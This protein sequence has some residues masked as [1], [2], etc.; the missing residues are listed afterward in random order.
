MKKKY[1]KNGDPFSVA[2]YIM[3]SVKEKTFDRETV[4]T[5][6]IVAIGKFIELNLYKKS[7]E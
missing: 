7:K 2:K 3:D 6:M 1:V 4:E 5:L